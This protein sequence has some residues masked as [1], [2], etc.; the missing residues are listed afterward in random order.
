[1][2]PPEELS[3]LRG[4]KRKRREGNRH[5]SIEPD[6]LYDSDGQSKALVPVTPTVQSIPSWDSPGLTATAVQMSGRPDAVVSPSADDNAALSLLTED[7]L[8]TV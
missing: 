8:T 6:A 1:M 4:E 7:G 5:Q 3:K 2:A